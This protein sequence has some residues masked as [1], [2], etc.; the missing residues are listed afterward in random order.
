MKQS[1]P[2]YDVAGNLAKRVFPLNKTLIDGTHNIVL[3]WK[4]RYY[5]YQ[6]I[7][8]E[9]AYGFHR[10]QLVAMKVI[11]GTNGKTT[12]YIVPTL[13]TDMRI[14][15]PLDVLACN[16]ESLDKLN[17][18]SHW[19]AIHSDRDASP[20][21]VNEPINVVLDEFAIDTRDIVDADSDGIAIET[22]FFVKGKKIE[23]NVKPIEGK[24]ADVS[25]TWFC[26]FST[27]TTKP[28]NE[29]LIPGR[30]VMFPGEAK[31]CTIPSIG[32]NIILLEPDEIKTL[33]SLT[34]HSLSEEDPYF[35]NS[36][37]ASRCKKILSHLLRKCGATNARVF[38]RHPLNID[39]F[40]DSST[41]ADSKNQFLEWPTVQGITELYEAKAFPDPD[42]AECPY[43]PKYADKNFVFVPSRPDKPQ[44]ADKDAPPP[45]PFRKDINVVEDFDKID[46]L[47]IIIE[48]RNY[49]MCV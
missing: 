15:E 3:F 24:E 35:V 19:N 26:C 46:E 36:S 5:W 1:T 27:S 10:N 33:V 42:T 45:G 31:F 40:Y 13:S 2:I 6:I 8:A 22:K 38:G 16:E 32:D 18:P 21:I 29:S 39:A 28:L 49:P 7:E 30:N 12:V 37:M 4:P 25:K 47:E 44:E 11:S 9:P 43:M 14:L 34:R 48:V 41:P 20:D 23:W 17:L